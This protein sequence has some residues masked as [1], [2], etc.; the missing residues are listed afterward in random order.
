MDRLS[1]ATLIGMFIFLIFMCCFFSLSETGMMSLNR[2]RLR[3]MVRHQN[4]AAKRVLALIESPDRLLGLILIGSTFANILVSAVFTL[5]AIRLWGEHSVALATIFLTFIV[6]IFGEIAPKT[7]AALHPLRV[8]LLVSGLIKFLLT[9][10]YPVVWLMNVITNGFLRLL[11][12][13]IKKGTTEVLSSEELR[14]LVHE[15]GAILPSMHKG[16][17]LSLL[18]LEK[19]TVDDIM[20]PKGEIKGIDLTMDME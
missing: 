13:K 5:L 1:D 19:L 2:Y 7:V 4:R 10:F 15:A 16:M 14:T 3:H 12:V 17:L 6:M 8:A 11:G 20:I 18:D 9:I